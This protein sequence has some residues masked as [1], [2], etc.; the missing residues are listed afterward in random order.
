MIRIGLISL[1]ILCSYF[2]MAQQPPLFS[3]YYVSDFYI[4]PA[5]SGSKTYNLFSIQTRQQW[6]GFEGAP[7]TTNVSYHGAINNRSAI[8]SYLMF[9]KSYPSLQA[10][11][12]LS[13]AY[14]I[15]LNYEKV[16]LSFGLGGKVMY[17]N[18]NFN[19][20]DLPP[21]YDEAF[22][23][24][25]YDKVLGDA[26]SGVYL[27]GKTFYFGVSTSN[28]LRSSFNNAIQGSPYLNNQFRNYYVIG[29]Y[30]FQIINQ[31]WRC[32]PSFLLR[33]T[34][35]INNIIDLS[36]RVLYLQDN[37]AGL[38]YRT[39]GTAVIL[40]GFSSGDIHFSYSYDH[41]LIGSIQKYSYGTHEIGI[42]FRIKTLS[43]ERHIGFWNY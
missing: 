43:S 31:D 42:G 22:S 37:W 11:L 4:N 29:A 17:H 35:N 36:A 25:S 23:T 19:E 34:E 12:H 13:Y 8:G 7:F 16:N 39:D 1:F 2:S 6:L 18:I 32:E 38:T 3:Q 21:G 24:S 30:N 40:F 28:I 26:S 5:I 14:H 9:D 20:G 15:P 33:K 41:T 27:Y 10:N